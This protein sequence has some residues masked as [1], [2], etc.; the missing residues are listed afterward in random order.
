MSSPWFALTS[1]MLVLLCQL[2]MRPWMKGPVDK[3][4]FIERLRL[5]SH[6]IIL[7]CRNKITCILLKE[8]V[9]FQVMAC[10]K[11]VPSS[12]TGQTGGPLNPGFHPPYTCPFFLP[13]PAPFSLFCPKIQISPTS[14]PPAHFFSL[15]PPPFPF[16]APKFR[17]PQRPSPLSSPTEM[18][19][20]PNGLNYMI[21][22]F[23]TW[24]FY[25][26][27]LCQRQ[28]QLIPSPRYCGV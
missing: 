6:C 4:H 26:G 5:N 12:L 10:D 25:I 24:I 27:V 3:R 21:T 2:R 15:P 14:T 19:V 1:D 11:W 18:C 17:S 28:G 13:P 7:W 20:T 22:I 16:F 23:F 9:H 8:M